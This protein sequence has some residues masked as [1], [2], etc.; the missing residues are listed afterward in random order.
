MVP[1]RS[2]GVAHRHTSCP[3]ALLLTSIVLPTVDKTK[4]LPVVDELPN[5]E[6]LVLL[7]ASVEV[8]LRKAA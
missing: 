3:C 6:L 5:V 2:R 8:S 4:H 7:E 1:E